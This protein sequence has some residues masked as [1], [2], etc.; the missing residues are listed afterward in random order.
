MSPH[1]CHVDTV[2]FAYV[3]VLCVEWM[4]YDKWWRMWWAAVY[5]LQLNISFMLQFGFLSAFWFLF[6]WKVH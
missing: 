5:I 2:D 4:M 3:I 1:K 6:W